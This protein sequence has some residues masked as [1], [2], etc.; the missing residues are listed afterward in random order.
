M[1]HPSGEGSSGSRNSP[2]Q[3]GEGVQVAGNDATSVDGT[4]VACLL[5]LVTVT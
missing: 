3:V 5:A 2:Q 4:V 1:P